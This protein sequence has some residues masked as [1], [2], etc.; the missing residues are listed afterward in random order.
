MAHLAIAGGSPVRTEAW[1]AW[2]QYDERE[3]R[4]L[5]EVLESRNW[6]GFPTP[7]VKAAEFADRFAAYHT[8]RYGICTSG[9]TTALEVALKSVGVRSGDEVIMPA[10]T[11]IATASAILSIGAA[12]VFVDVHPDSWCIDPDLIEEAITERTRAILPVHFA[13]R[14]ADMDRILDI[15]RR[16]GL[17][18]VED[19]AHMHGGFWRGRGAGSLGDMGAFS[20]QSSKTMTAGEGGIVI[21]NDEAAFERARAYI[22]AG[23]TRRTDR[24]IGE[25]H[26]LGWNY[27]ITEWQAA[28][29]LAQLDRLPEQTRKR[30]ENA[31]YL[32]SLIESI[33][34]VRMFPPEPRMTQP[35]GYG[36]VI[37]YNEEAFAGVRRDT[38]VRALR[39]EGI[40]CEGAFYTAVYKSPLFAWE[41]APGPPPYRERRCPVAER[42]GEREMVWIPHEVLLAE[43]S[44]MDDIAAAIVKVREH[45][46]ELVAFERAALASEGAA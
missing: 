10:L 33:D 46:D 23:R 5:M 24:H 6:G 39:A 35:A 36:Y 29:L 32:A 4:G 41:D 31:A 30:A 45:L 3:R 42:A 34:G 19:C 12:P 20:F 21:T 8:A 27:R 11:F 7:N 26:V 44:D 2:P 17:R 37:V 15:A 1:P 38:F 9:G 14:M 28:V 43:R 16:H 40:K 18:V 13:S 22:N 25:R